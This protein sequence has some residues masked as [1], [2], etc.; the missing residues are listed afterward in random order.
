VLILSTEDNAETTIRPRL[1]AAGADLSRVQLVSVKDALFSVTQDLPALKA[2]IESIGDVR[3]V[4]I[5]PL[6]GHL[7][8]TD[9]HRNA[10]VR[11]ALGPLCEM[12]ART[13]VAVLAIA[14]LNK[15]GIGQGALARINGSVAFGAVARAA[16]LA[17]E[18][19]K[20]E[21][22]RLLLLVK[23]NLGP[24]AS[25]LAY[26][27]EGRNG[28]PPVIAWGEGVDLRADDALQAITEQRGSG[29][30][31][32]VAATWLR[33]QLA[34]EGVPAEG[35][36]AADLRE[37]A[38]RDGLA[39]RTVERASQDIGVLKSREGFGRG[40]FW[41][42]PRPSEAASDSHSRQVFTPG[43]D[44]ANGR[45]GPRTGVPS[46]DGANGGD[47]GDP[48]ARQPAEERRGRGAYLGNG[49]WTGDDASEEAS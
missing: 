41:C 29:G 38:S 18:D 23:S 22:R 7:G 19:P 12:A 43:A 21:G 3:L 25:G 15:G 33:T 30:A 27:V 40:S 34:R 9:S 37:R 4:I 46:P 11:G 47:A 39:W 2:K 35:V 36:P 32:S 13:G 20:D 1:K 48:T 26:R 45:T 44:G 28:Q 17:V 5:D 16:W 10:D 8:S 14:H 49:K 6:A 42:L 31:A 24:R